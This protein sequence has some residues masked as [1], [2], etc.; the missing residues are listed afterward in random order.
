MTPPAQLSSLTNVFAN[1]LSGLLGFGAIALFVMLVIGGFQ[2]A[3]AGGDPKAQVSAWRTLT[4]A[5]VGLILVAS[6]YLI[7]TL[8]AEFTGAETILDFDVFLP[9]GETGGRPQ[10]Q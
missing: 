7:I 3:F 1:A 6:A 10:T 9:G 8:I 5:F 2:F 4:F